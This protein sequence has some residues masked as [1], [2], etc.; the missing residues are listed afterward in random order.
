MPALI[1]YQ[2][3]DFDTFAIRFR[4]RPAAASQECFDSIFKFARTERLSEII[5]SA[6]FETATLSESASCAVRNS[7]GV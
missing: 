5:V 1:D 2:I 6:C 3:A 7:A 4:W